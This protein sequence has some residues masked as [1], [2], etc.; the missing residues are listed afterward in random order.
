MAILMVALVLA[1]ALLTLAVLRIRLRGTPAGK[2]V[3]A[4]AAAEVPLPYSPFQSM[5]FPT[6]ADLLAD[7][8]SNAPAIF[9]PTASGNP[10]SALFGSTR[11]GNDGLS[12]FHA[13]IDVAPLRRD[14][15]GK[16]LDEVVAVADG[17]VGYVNRVGGDSSYGAYVVLVHE[18]PVGPVYSLY[19]HL[20]S[21][22]KDLRSGSKVQAG[23][24]IGV[25]GH[26][27]STGI[28]RAR[29]H[30]H[31]EFGTVLSERFGPWARARKIKPDRGTYHGWNLFAVDPLA[32]FARKKAEANRFTFAGF[33]A[34]VPCAFELVVRVSRRPDYFTRYPSLWHG[35]AESGGGTV[36]LGVSEGGVILSGRMANAIELE[37]SGRAKVP[38]VQNVNE[39]VLGRNG[40][41]LIA[42]VRGVWTLG[43]AASRWLDV[44]TY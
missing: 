18:D 41:H 17:K 19:A 32:V 36:V 39:A 28:P 12:R 13:G 44:L 11:T 7:P 6:V 15:S 26:S 24:V 34:S 22:A 38:L 27:A 31:F 43:R 30:L 37:A 1:I 42:K 3:P 25:M 2:P 23:T 16:P 35:P 10:Q 40:M 33:L 5:V 8:G 20:A 14:R 9:M 21:V 4:P 29:A